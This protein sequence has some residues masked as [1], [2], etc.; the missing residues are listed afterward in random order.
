[1]IKSTLLATVGVGALVVFFASTF[2]VSQTEQALVLQFGKPVRMVQE[3]GLNFK[4]PFVQNVEFYEKRLIDFDADPKEVIAADQKRLM[5]DAF[6]R[7]HITNPLRFKQTVGTETTMRSR[8]NSILESSLRQVIGSV[9]LSAVISEKR[10]EIMQ[11]IRTQVN[12]QAM[13]GDGKGGFGI[14][15][16]DVR[17]KRAD[18]PQANSEG[19]Y[20]RMQTEREREA[21]QFR[22]QGSED[23]QKIR[24]QA[25]KE[26]TIILAEAQKTAQ[27]T[28]GEGDSQ[29]TKIFADA[30]G[31]DPE[32][33]K[34]YRSMQAYKKSISNKD[35][36]IVM[37]P[38]SEFLQYM[39]KGA[40]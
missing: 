29:A 3:P 35:T 38:D 2:V 14:E 5:V 13:G 15:V 20:K 8:L 30:F 22:A 33:F 24:S 16:I 19:I 27:I 36:T 23:A 17:I 7:Y 12:E 31:K 18:L 11:N 32:F 34:F 6:V 40:N 4:L 26:R 37:S 28:R 1:M 10:A 21:N 25:D 9:P 39:G